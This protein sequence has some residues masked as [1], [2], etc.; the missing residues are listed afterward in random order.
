MRIKLFCSVRLRV[1]FFYPFLAESINIEFINICIV[2]WYRSVPCGGFLGKVL[3][4]LNCEVCMQPRIH[5]Q[6]QIIHC[7]RYMLAQD[8]LNNVSILLTEYHDGKESNRCKSGQFYSRHR[9]CLCKCIHRIV[10]NI[11]LV[12]IGVGSQKEKIH[13][14]V[15]KGHQW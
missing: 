14:D 13:Q 12:Q 1:V 7:C 15:Q 9:R 10:F 2:S 5:F 6:P 8:R 4:R 3:G 11:F